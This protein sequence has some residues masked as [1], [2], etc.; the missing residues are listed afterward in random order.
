MTETRITCDRCAAPIPADRTKLLVECGPIRARRD[1]IDLCPVCCD[2][3]EAFLRDP[4]Q[5][6]EP[7]TCS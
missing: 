5:R 4:S 2:R 7:S 1:T 3:F 6:E